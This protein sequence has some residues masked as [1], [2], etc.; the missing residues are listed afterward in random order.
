MSRDSNKLGTRHST[1]QLLGDKTKLS[2]DN[3]PKTIFSTEETHQSNPKISQKSSIKVTKMVQRNPPVERKL[4]HI[5][6]MPYA[7]K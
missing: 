7:I 3:H 1:E 4:A 6:S 5:L 2:I